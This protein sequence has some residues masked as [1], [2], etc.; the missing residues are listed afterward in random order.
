MR[1]DPDFLLQLVRLTASELYFY[2]SPAAPLDYLVHSRVIH[3]GGAARRLSRSR[4]TTFCAMVTLSCLFQFSFQNS[5]LSIP[6]DNYKM[7][8]TI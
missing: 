5:Y 6:R 1:T 4:R 8:R 3:L 2:S 7:Q